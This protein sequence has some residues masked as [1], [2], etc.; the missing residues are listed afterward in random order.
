[1]IKAGTILALTLALTA[2]SR[3]QA[4]SSASSVAPAASTTSEQERCAHGGVAAASDPSCKASSD[5]RFRKFLNGGGGDE[6]RS[7]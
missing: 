4:T 1:M 6:H 3:Q 2:C 7:R 5:A